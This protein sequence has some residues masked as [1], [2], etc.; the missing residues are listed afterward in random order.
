LKWITEI[1]AVEIEGNKLKRR[2]EVSGAT[3]NRELAL[4]KRMFNLAID[5]DHYL[6]SNPV[7]KVKFFQEFN[8][9]RR[10]L[11]LAEE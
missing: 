6:G 8:T 7:R 11:P 4:L 1:T 5:W 3:V 2:S 9:G 10:V